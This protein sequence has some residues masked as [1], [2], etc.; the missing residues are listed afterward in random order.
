MELSTLLTAGLNVG[1][2]CNVSWYNNHI[3]ESF[4]SVYPFWI[5]RYYSNDGTYDESRK[6]EAERLCMWQYTSRGSV[7]GIAGNVDI[8]AEYENP[9]ENDSFSDQTAAQSV[10]FIPGQN[11]TLKVPVNVR[12]GPSVNYP[13]VG[14]NNLT[15]D[16]KRH[17]RDR[18]GSL[19]AG[20]VVTCKEVAYE[21]QNVWIKCPSGWLCAIENN[22]VYIS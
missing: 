17:D 18:S 4:K 1:I 20:T 11:Y 2:Y 21:G 12:K 14:Y 5:A 10:E 13:K 6:P 9:F 16:G 8:S 7:P 22:N 3:P 19:D 15:P